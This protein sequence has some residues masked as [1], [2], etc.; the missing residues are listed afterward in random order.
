MYLVACK[1]NEK[2]KLVQVLK[3]DDNLNTPLESINVALIN[4]GRY[5]VETSSRPLNYSVDRNNEVVQ[6]VGSFSRLASFEPDSKGNFKIASVILNEIQD[7]KGGTIGYKVLNCNNY[8]ITLVSVKNLIALSENY[9]TP[10]IQNAIFRN[11]SINCYPHKQFLVIIKKDS[12]VTKDSFDNWFDRATKNPNYDMDL[13][14]FM[15]MN[16]DLY[17]AEKFGKEGR[18]K[19]R[20][21][22]IITGYNLDAYNKALITLKQVSMQKGIPLSLKKA[23]KIGIRYIGE[24]SSK[25]FYKY[26]VNKY[27]NG[28]VSSNNKEH[29][30]NKAQN[31]ELELCKKNGIDPELISD[32]RLSN[33]Q[34]RVI[35][36]SKQNGAMSECFNKPEF[37]TSAMKFY[38]DHLFLPEDKER[39][40]K[41]LSYPE[42][43]GSELLELSN[44]IEDNV[45]YEDLIGESDIHIF[46]EREHRKNE[47]LPTEDEIMLRDK[48]MKYRMRLLGFV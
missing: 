7:E 28:E 22:G 45:E 33:S 34:M 1:Y 6:D 10:I 9:K 41:L 16:K 20:R 11:G 47:K 23:S 29:K 35:W 15:T 14:D 25:K 3:F 43:S 44:C 37:S 26:L 31:K 42:L 36:K 32:D 2:D 24:D 39:Y 13:I 30:Y 46:V 18:N 12:K 21:K 19:Q 27:G 48:A 4:L 38:A 17:V 40:S 5:T 8:N